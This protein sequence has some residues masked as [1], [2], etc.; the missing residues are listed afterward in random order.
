MIFLL[1][2]DGTLLLSGGAGRIALEQATDLH[3][4]RRGAMDRVTCA[5]KTDLLILEDACAAV[6]GHPPGDDLLKAILRSYAEFLPRA[7]EEVTNFRLMPGVPQVIHALRRRSDAH[8]SV[9]TGNIEI[10]A[11]LKLERAGLADLLPVGGYADRCR[12]RTD[13][14]IRAMEAAAAAACRP[15]EELGPTIVV[16]DTERDVQAARA[17]GL[18][19]AVLA[20]TTT[21]VEVLMEAEPDLIMEDLRELLPWSRQLK[22]R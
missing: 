12:E 3:L 1:D 14:L 6:L 7:L 21:P 4:P 22:G 2:I 13:V 10:G 19:A 15:L 16:G 9:A 5:G 8:L 18:Y 20:D 11:R 17:L